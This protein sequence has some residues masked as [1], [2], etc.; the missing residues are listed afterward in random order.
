M[1]AALIAVGDELTCGYR[2]DTN[3]QFI[4]QQLAALPLDVVLHLTVGD[5]TAAIQAA[6][7]MAMDVAKVIVVAGGLGPTEDDLT[8]QAVA[9]FFQRSLEENP[10]ALERMQERFARRGRSMPERNRTQAQIPAGSQPILNDRGTAAG[11][12]L[13]ES[14]RHIF[15]VPGVPYEMAGMMAGFILPR[16][17]QITS[18]TQAVR[19]GVLKVFGIP[20]SEV[21]QRIAAM[22][23]RERNP[24]LGLLPRLGTITVEIVA[25]G[26]TPQ[27]AQALLDADRQALQAI[28]GDAV[29]CSDERTLPEVVGD[30]LAQQGLQLAVAEAVDG[31]GG[32]IAA[33]L[34]EVAG[35]GQWF[36]RGEV[37]EWRDPSP[38]LLAEQIRRSAA[39]DAGLV[40]G[41]LAMPTDAAPG[42]PYGVIHV[43]VDLN[44][45]VVE[46][47][48]SYSGER[49]WVRQFA[50]SA[51]VNMLRLQ[52]LGRG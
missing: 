45:A 17:Q 52:L 18:G 15:A 31:T 7:G 37:R 41:P 34:T 36:R 35:S 6:L 5:E 12:Y 50:A 26:A 48:L 22:M 39:A 44:G 25:K 40:S 51:A 28:L 32:A 27:Q 24:L 8:R 23:G 14:G 49:G 19:R 13:P 43:A 11:F 21:A 10:A 29:L 20:E 33:C 42:R 47:R 46:Q 3:S 16:L 2:L 4:A 30:L 9:Q 1:R 38:R